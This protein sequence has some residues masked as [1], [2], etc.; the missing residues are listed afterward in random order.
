ME[1][2]RFEFS[3][4]SSNKFW[5]IARDGAALLVTFGKIGTAGQAQRK[6]LASEAAAIAEHDKLV[7]EKTKKGYVAVATDAA[8]AGPAPVPKVKAPKAM[9]KAPKALKAPRAAKK[10]PKAH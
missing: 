7:K 10:A 1:P 6:E 3:D 8:P 5:Q 9:K 2:K 4:G